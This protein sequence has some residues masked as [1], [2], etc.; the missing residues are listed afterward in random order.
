M[1]VAVTAACAPSKEDH[2]QRG[3]DL[4]AER[5]WAEAA[6]EYE[7]AL[8]L[9][10]GY[11]EARARLADALEKSNPGDPQRIRTERLRAAELL[12]EHIDVQYKA[13]QSLLVARRWDA[14]DLRADLILKKDPESWQGRLLKAGA[15]AGRNDEAGA[16]A[17]IEE[18]IRMAPTAAD[19]YVSL[20]SCVSVNSAATT[21]KRPSARPSS[22]GR[23]WPRDTPVSANTTGTWGARR[24]PN[25]R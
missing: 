25:A 13:G 10:H 11:G 14:V 5:K 20:A 7:Q 2:L 23:R 8:A 19:P 4:F 16:A 3:D 1:I 21:P 12:P 18:A 17:P 9:D 24:T 6:A 15:A 22:S